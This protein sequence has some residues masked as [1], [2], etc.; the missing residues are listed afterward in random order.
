MGPNQN[1]CDSRDDIANIER[2]VCR[3]SHRINTGNFR[4]KTLQRLGSSLSAR[5]LESYVG[6]RRLLVFVLVVKLLTIE[7]QQSIVCF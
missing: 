3:E 5:S 7:S 6:S 2:R 1:V 4:S